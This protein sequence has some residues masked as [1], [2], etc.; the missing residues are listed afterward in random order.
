MEIRSIFPPYNTKKIIPKE[1]REYKKPINYIDL[2]GKV[3][4]RLTVIER[5]EDYIAPNGH[6][7]AQWLCECKCRTKIIALGLCLRNGS[8]KSCG[9]GKTKLCSRHE[10]LLASELKKYYI[11][12]YNAKKEYK[13]IKNPETDCWLR[14]DIY[15]PKYKIFIEVNGIQHYKFVPHWNKTVE[16]FEYNQKLYQL[17]KEYA[18]QNGIFIEIDLREINEIDEAIVYINSIIDRVSND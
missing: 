5:A 15:I 18:Q 12:N 16:N 11:K 17:K 3:F 4:G 7:S 13:I 2:T 10:S 14:C 1:D 8:T 6:H 9:S